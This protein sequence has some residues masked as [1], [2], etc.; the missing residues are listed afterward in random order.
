M[1]LAGLEPATVG[2]EIRCSI[3]LSYRRS[4]AG[5]EINDSCSRRNFPAADE[6]PKFSNLGSRLFCFVGPLNA[7]AVHPM[8]VAFPR[9]GDPGPPYGDRASRLLACK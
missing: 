4:L 9:I 1:R 8:Q 2:F 3:Q 7:L 5:V 6:C